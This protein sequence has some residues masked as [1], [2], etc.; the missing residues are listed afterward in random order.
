MRAWDNQMRAVLVILKSPETLYN[1]NSLS[2]VLGLT[3]MGTLKILKR[4]EKEGVL[5]KEKMGKAFFYRINVGNQHARKYLQFALSKE[6]LESS[7]SVKR[8]VNEIK[9]IKNA[10]LAILFGSVLKK[11]DP[12][13]IDV[14]FLTDQKKFRKLE[15]EIE[16]INQINVKKIHPVYQT[17]DDLAENIKKKD[18]VILNAVKGV[19]VFGEGKFIKIYESCKK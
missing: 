2:R 14:L 10:D 15:K 8:W 16:G 6:G 12:R 11:S 7:A 3:A 1:A 18:K 17:F 13:D 9:K 4:L 19:V 5:L